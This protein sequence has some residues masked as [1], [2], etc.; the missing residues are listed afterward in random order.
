MSKTYVVSHT[1]HDLSADFDI[2]RVSQTFPL[3]LTYLDCRKQGGYGDSNLEPPSNL[4]WL[5]LLKHVPVVAGNM[6]Y[7][8]IILNYAGYLLSHP[9][10]HLFL[11]RK[12]H[13]LCH[14]VVTST[15]MSSKTFLPSPF[16]LVPILV[17]ACLP[18]FLFFWGLQL[19]PLILGVPRLMAIDISPS[20]G[21][22]TKMT[23]Q[24]LQDSL[25][26]HQQSN[27]RW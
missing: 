26:Y 11:S 14:F 12:H 27:S 2:S 10:V 22:S 19:I 21:S 6:S 5:M 9:S 7:S 8:W 20:W 18:S 24:N 17:P 16:L 15:C 23:E 25:V 13:S 3:I 4:F 1:E